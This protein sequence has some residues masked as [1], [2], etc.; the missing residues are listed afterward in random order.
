[1]SPK[2]LFIRIIFTAAYKP[3]GRKTRIMIFLLEAALVALCYEMYLNADQLFGFIYLF[4]F[5][6]SKI[7]QIASLATIVVCLGEIATAQ[8]YEHWLLKRTKAVANQPIMTRENYETF[9][10]RKDRK[11]VE[12]SPFD[13]HQRELEAQQVRARATLN[14]VSKK[15]VEARQ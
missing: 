14:L 4:N 9:W 1:M 2:E 8:L 3:T 12:D 10:D 13:I 11:Y 6:V 5:P 15:A 7:A